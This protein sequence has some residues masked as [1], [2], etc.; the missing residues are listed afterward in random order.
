MAGPCP[1]RVP[2]VD[3]C[4]GSAVACWF[5]HRPGRRLREGPTRSL[6]T[7]CF[8]G[9]LALGGTLVR[10]CS[11]RRGDH[12]GQSGYACTIRNSRAPDRTGTARQ[13]PPTCTPHPHY[14]LA[15]HPHGL[16]VHP[17]HGRIHNES[18]FNP[19]YTRVY[20]HT[21]HASTGQ[22]HRSPSAL[23]CRAKHNSEGNIDSINTLADRAEPRDMS[24]AKA[25][26][27]HFVAH[28]IWP[29]LYVKA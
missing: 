22:G 25:S 20:S 16:Y 8:R 29:L 5:W 19:R 15:R 21:R 6:D 1:Y 23:E 4:R 17:S 12:P 7:P 14:P 24:A 28:L 18:C 2:H 9:V 10:I 3:G 11:A 26:A 27:E 13:Q